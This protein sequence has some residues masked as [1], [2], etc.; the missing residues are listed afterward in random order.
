MSKD[1]QTQP[2]TA[3]QDEG[4]SKTQLKREMQALQ[5]TG[6]RLANL[7]PEQRAQL[8]I[9]DSL[10]AALEEHGRLRH[11]EAR[12]RHLQYIGKLIREEDTERLQ[13][14]LDGFA[15][16]SSED[17]RRQQLGERWRDQL[18]ADDSNQ[19]L[20]AFTGDFP[21]SDVQH[22][23]N[24]LRNVRRAQDSDKYP[25]ANRKLY[26]YLREQI[27]LQENADLL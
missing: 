13:R 10:A 3:E 16:G 19:A 9:S 14:Q 4:P 23:R 11:R 12:R 2:E 26:R 21:D 15:S 22:L 25:G 27:D 6:E 20:T 5:E 8:P 18:L 24:L 17:N 7:K 1:P